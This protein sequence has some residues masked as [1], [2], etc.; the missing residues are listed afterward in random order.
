M[1]SPLIHK[2]TTKAPRTH[3]LKGLK[4]PVLSRKDEKK[5]GIGPASKI[6]RSGMPIKGN[7]AYLLGGDLANDGSIPIK[8]VKGVGEEPWH[9]CH[10]G[11][12]EFSHL[13]LNHYAAATKNL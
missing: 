10:R 2:I 11:I 5:L 12:E 7:P 8:G 9:L 13:H 4:G 6:H 1:V 3:S